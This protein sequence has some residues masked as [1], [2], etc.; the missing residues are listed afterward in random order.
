LKQYPDSIKNICGIYN[1]ILISDNYE[2]NYISKRDGYTEYIILHGIILPYYYISNNNYV[3]AQY[4]FKETPFYSKGIIEIYNNKKLNYIENI[5]LKIKNILNFVNNYY[6]LY[7]GKL[8]E[9]SD[10][11]SIFNEYN[12]IIESD[13]IKKEDLYKYL[14]YI[15]HKT[16]DIK[17]KF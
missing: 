17:I 7:L 9:N 16:Y 11:N 10:N 4:K 3:K 6:Y 13:I 2:Y 12:E 5:S 15:I 8:V 14:K 1:N